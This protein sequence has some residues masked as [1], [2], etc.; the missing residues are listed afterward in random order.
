MVA[1]AQVYLGS[2][3]TMDAWSSTEFLAEEYLR[4]LTVLLP[5]VMDTQPAW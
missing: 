4:Y 3:A 5:E 1:R 2:E